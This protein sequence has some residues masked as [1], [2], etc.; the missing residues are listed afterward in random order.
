MPDNAAVQDVIFR[1]LDEVKARREA[2]TEPPWEYQR[3]TTEKGI[4]EGLVV[5]LL[6]PDPI[7]VCEV[8]KGGFYYDG[9]KTGTFIAHAGTDVPRLERMVRAAAEYLDELATDWPGSEMKRG[10]ESREVLEEMRRI[11]EGEE[12]ARGG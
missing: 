9:G 10:R 6:K 7:V 4:V 12:E 1:Y 3:S 2:A 8:E 11:A 5:A